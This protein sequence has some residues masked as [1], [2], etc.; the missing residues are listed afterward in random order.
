MSDEDFLKNAIAST[1]DEAENSQDDDGIDGSDGEDIDGI[2]ADYG[3]EKDDDYA[4]E[5]SNKSEGGDSEGDK[6]EDLLDME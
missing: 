4:F 3:D 6:K 1:D 2:D 5:R